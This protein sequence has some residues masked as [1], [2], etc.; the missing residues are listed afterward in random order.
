MDANEM[1]Y[2]FD[3]LYDSIASLTSPGY[4]AKE[5][6]LLL[7]NAQDIVVDKL[8]PKEFKEKN[9]R[10][11]DNILRTVDIST[12]SVT[13]GTGKP[14]GSRYDLPSDFMYHESEEVTVSSTADCFNGNRIMV[15]AGRQDEYSIQIKNPHKKPML[16]GSDYDNVW[17]LDYNDNTNGIKRVDLITDGTFTIATYHLTYMKRPGPIT[18]L[19]SGDTSTTVQSDC[20][21]DISIHRQIVETAIRIATGITNPQEYQIKINEET[22]NNN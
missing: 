14:N 8:Q 3:V 19:L 4:T 17:R 22:L 13:Q 6:S 5:K 2:Q 11:L 7:T 18:P 20:E 21:L 9:R 10:A 16:S 12:A 1:S 15:H